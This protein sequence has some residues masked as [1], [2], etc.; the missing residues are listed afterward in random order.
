MKISR[1]ISLIFAVYAISVHAEDN[2]T[3][4]FTSYPAAVS[5]GPFATKLLPN[6]LYEHHTDEWKKYIQSELVKPV[7]FAGHYRIAFT[8]N[9]SFPQ[10]CGNDGWVCGWII[11]KKTGEIIS[12]LPEFNGN[13]KYF[14]S[15][16]N[17]TPSPDLFD[18]EYY[19]NS[20][21]IWISG[22]NKPA[23][24]KRGEIKCSITA[25][26]L[27]DKKFKKIVS[28]RCEIDV[29]DDADADSYLP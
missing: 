8:K 4:K 14:P 5:H 1:L 22:Q 26:N 12:E 24:N 9:G 27:K 21:M 25:Y 18:A 7:N 13:T 28:S 6:D 16:D 10:D 20:S 19:L 3:A 11:D 2:T 29:G 15:I 23:N 17:G